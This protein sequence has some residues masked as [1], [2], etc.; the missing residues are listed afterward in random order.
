M[1]KLTILQ[2]LPAS[3]K[4]TL[5]R[6]IVAKTGNTKRV[7]KDDIRALLDNSKWSKNNEKFVLKT[8]DFLIEEALLDGFNVVSDDTNLH[9]KHIE[10]MKIIAKKYNAALETKFINTPIDECIKRD[11]VRPNSVGEAVI[12]SMYDQFLRPAP[13]VYTEDDKLPH[14]FLCDIDGTV[15]LLGD[16]SVYDGALVGLDTPHKPVCQIVDSMLRAGHRVV[17]LSGRDEICR[18]QTELWIRANVSQWFDTHGLGVELYMRPQGDQRKDSIVKK[19]L[20]ESKI[21]GQ[22]YVDM[23]LDDRPSVCRMWRNELGLNVIQIGD[24]YKEF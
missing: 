6:E 19:E 22:Y 10:T 13:I 12:Q 1:P 18:R 23:V 9:P 5:A 24:P 20:F 16:R 3:G 7:N 15:A 21:R 4:S 8:R 11:L 17:F 14:I 2:G